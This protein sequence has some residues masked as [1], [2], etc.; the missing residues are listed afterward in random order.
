MTARLAR[1]VR[2]FDAWFGVQIARGTRNE[3][4]EAMA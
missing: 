4:W 2:W 3:I 1:D